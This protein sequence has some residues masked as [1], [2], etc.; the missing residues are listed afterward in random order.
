MQNLLV[1]FLV[2][3][4]ASNVLSMIDVVD[5]TLLRHLQ[6]LTYTVSILFNDIKTHNGSFFYSVV[7]YSIPVTLT[8]SFP[9]K[10]SCSIVQ[11]LTS[12][13]VTGMRKRQR[14]R[15]QLLL[16]QNFQTLRKFYNLLTIQ[17][18]RGYGT[19]P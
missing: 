18:C 4:M 15:Y 6:M 17:S 3:G 12:I 13:S 7:F 10:N 8:S 19:N 5:F 16:L 14:L 1:I 11:M 9:F 2:F